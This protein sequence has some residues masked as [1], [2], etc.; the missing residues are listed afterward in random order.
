MYFK[1]FKMVEYGHI[2][3]EMLLLSSVTA[4]WQNNWK[5]WNDNG[6]SEE[7]NLRPWNIGFENNLIVDLAVR[8]LY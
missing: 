8:L 3:S 7:T 6:D 4:W 1:E 2:E 5:C